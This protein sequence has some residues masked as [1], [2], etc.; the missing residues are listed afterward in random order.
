[1]GK[2]KEEVKTK[3]DS[4]TNEEIVIKLKNELE[5]NI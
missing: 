3:Y 1:M 2:F 5:K 4:L